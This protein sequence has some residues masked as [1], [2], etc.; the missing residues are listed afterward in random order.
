MPLRGNCNVLKPTTATVALNFVS[1]GSCV[2][3]NVNC[4]LEG[5]IGA[6]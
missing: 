4:L 5:K 3:G 1:G 2:S 6:I